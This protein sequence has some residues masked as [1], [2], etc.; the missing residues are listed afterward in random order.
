[1]LRSPVDLSNLTL[2]NK[3]NQLKKPLRSFESLSPQLFSKELQKF[4]FCTTLIKLLDMETFLI[5]FQ[6]ILLEKS[7][8]VVG[9]NLKEVTGVIM[10]LKQLV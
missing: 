5:L 1:M 2:L 9:D 8:I 4:W 6:S 3:L 10:G 7:V